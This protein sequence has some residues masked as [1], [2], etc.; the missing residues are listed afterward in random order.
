MSE[1]LAKSRVY[2]A[3]NRLANADIVAQLSNT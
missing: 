2:L 1:N 3:F